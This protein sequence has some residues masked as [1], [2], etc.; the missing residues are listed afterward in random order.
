VYIGTGRTNEAETYLRSLSKAGNVELAQAG[1]YYTGLYLATQK[2]YELARDTLSSLA[3]GAPGSSFTNDAIQVAWVIEEGLMLQSP[4]LDDYMAM[5]KA[6]MVGDT[7]AMVSNLKA[8]TE[9]E[10]HDPLRPRAL[11]KLGLVLFDRGSYDA[12]IAALQTYLKDYPKNDECPTVTR[13]VGRVYEVGLGRY[14]DALQEYE[15]ILLSYPDY[16]M[17]DDVRRDVQRVRS[18]MKGSYAP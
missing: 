6:A 16:A 12:A 3:E 7:T 2:K 10:A 5:E 11:H 9:R 17:L 8:I 18:L 15:K 4:S 13:D 1:Q 14:H